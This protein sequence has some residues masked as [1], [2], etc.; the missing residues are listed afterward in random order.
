MFLSQGMSEKG[1]GNRAVQL[2]EFR[3]PGS[4]DWGD[5]WT[6]AEK[7]NQNRAAW[8]K[9]PAGRFSG[10]ADDGGGGGD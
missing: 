7:K 5:R 10:K 9:G 8:H 3:E 1:P 2:C 4:T 6:C